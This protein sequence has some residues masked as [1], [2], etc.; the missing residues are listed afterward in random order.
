MGNH[1]GNVSLLR[2]EGNVLK[3]KRYCFYKAFDE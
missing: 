3:T 2:G 1:E